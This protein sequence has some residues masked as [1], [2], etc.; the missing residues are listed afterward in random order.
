MALAPF[1]DRIYGAVGGHLS[2]SRESL[3][4]SLAEITVGLKCG[5]H[6]SLNDE[7]IA[8]LST[9]MMARLYPRLAI[10][11]PAKLSSH[12]KELASSINPAIE[13]AESSP[14]LTTLCIGLAVDE[15]SLFP[16]A[17]GWVARLGHSV[18]HGKSVPNPYAASAAAALACAEL[19]RRCF[20]K[21]S[22]EDDVSVSLLDFTETGGADEK[23]RLGVLDEVAF[24]GAGAIGNAALWAL[25]RHANLRGKIWIIDPEDLT[26][27]NLQRYVLGTIADVARPKVCLAEDALRGALSVHPSKMTLEKFFELRGRAD[28]PTICISVDN[29]AG[30]RSA[31]GFLPRL[32]VNGW[33]GDQGLGA[34]W[35]IFSRDA[36]CLACLYHPHGQG[37]S[38]T[39]Q[40]ARALGLTPD[41]ATLLWVTRQP[42]S[43]E[44]I[45]TA[46]RSLGVS[47]DKL[48]PWRNKPIGE[49]YTDLVCGAMPLDLTGVGKLETVPLVHQSALAGILMAAELVKRSD[50][51]LAARSQQ[52]A[53]VSWDDILRP[54][55]KLWRKPRAREVGC[56]CGDSDYQ[57]VYRSKWRTSRKKNPQSC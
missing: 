51:K 30:R 28:V 8:E 24:V 25:S 48:E 47:E 36:A 38:A 45:R 15:G 50:R 52:E 12:L 53:L 37:L 13:F 2:A 27:L 29:V 56:I 43:Q 23:L 16:S 49:L 21:T 7:W 35:H 42:L 4:A 44:D 5:E 1:F 6:H 40:A 26:L 41:R 46:A 55:P 54:P 57:T 34:S 17:S 31:Q 10:M 32:V 3:V 22:P 18:R 9:N 19:F 39:E 11:G 33:T 14:L 20:L